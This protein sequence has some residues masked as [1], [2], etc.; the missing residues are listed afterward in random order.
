MNLNPYESP[1]DAANDEQRFPNLGRTDCPA[2][3][4]PQQWFAFFNPWHRCRACGSFL[5]LKVEGWIKGAYYLSALYLY[6]RF[7][8]ID[9]QSSFATY[10]P[11]AFYVVSLF[12]LFKLIS[13][14]IGLTYVVPTKTGTG[15]PLVFY[16]E[17]V[18]CGYGAF[19]LICYS[20][21]SANR[22]VMQIV[23]FFGFCA[24]FLHF[25]VSAGKTSREGHPEP[26]ALQR[27]KQDKLIWLVVAVALVAAIG[28]SLY[29]FIFFS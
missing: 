5:R 18:L 17:F 20:Y 23:L 12:V 3:A 16:F 15:L 22:A 7:V 4:T 8:P 26:P 2:C 13:P 24:A 6:G 29:F 28:G 9:S 27:S 11:F 25:L 10:A 21:F 1:R 14:R 19:A